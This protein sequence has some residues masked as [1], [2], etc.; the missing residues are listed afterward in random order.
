MRAG[1]RPRGGSAGSP[2]P[3][4]GAR[5]TR[6]QGRWR[7]SIAPTRSA[8]HH[9]AWPRSRAARREPGRDEE[10]ADH[11]GRTPISRPFVDVDAAPGRRTRLCSSVSSGDSLRPAS[12]AAS[13]GCA[14]FIAIVPAIETTTQRGPARRGSGSAART[15]LAAAPG[16]RTSLRKEPRARAS[17]LVGDRHPEAFGSPRAADVG[18]VAATSRR[19]AGRG[20]RS[21]RGT[22]AIAS[23]FPPSSCR[24]SSGLS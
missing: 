14:R 20:L 15:R 22:A 12:R 21:R 4:R 24:R 23:S 2:A 13:R 8:I 16:S 18:R 10:A 6:S 17:R 7:S 3:R 9:S 19:R 1:R 5:T 11:E